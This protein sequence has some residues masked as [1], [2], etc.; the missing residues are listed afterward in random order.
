[1]PDDILNAR[2][3]WSDPAAYDAQA[4]RLVSM[5]KENFKQF[6]EL[7]TDEVKAAGPR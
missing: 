7:V 3:T 2:N 4:A 6:E 1:M 5:F